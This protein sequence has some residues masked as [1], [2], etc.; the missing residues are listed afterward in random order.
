[1]RVRDRRGGAADR[2][3][4]RFA[5]LDPDRVYC[6]TVRRAPSGREPRPVC[7]S[8][9]AR[10]RRPDELGPDS[11]DVPRI[12]AVARPDNGVLELRLGNARAGQLVDVT[13]A[14]DGRRWTDL[15]GR[16]GRDAFRLT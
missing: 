16:D 7:E 4:A 8:P 9:F 14:S 15:T 3:S 13:R 6:A 5:G 1:M 2:W 11:A 12:A 10:R